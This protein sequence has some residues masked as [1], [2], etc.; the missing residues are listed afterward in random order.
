MSSQIVRCYDQWVLRRPRLTLAVVGLLTLFLGFF[1][2][3]FKLDASGDSLVLENDQALKYYIGIKQQYASDDYLVLTYTPRAPL[4]SQPVLEDLHRL[5]QALEGVDNTASVLSIL[6]VPLLAS[7]P[8]TLNELQE[9]IRT[10]RD[11]DADLALARQEFLTS[12]IYSNLLVSPEATTT[13]LLISLEVDE[14]RR[15]LRRQR[16]ALRAAALGPDFSDQQRRELAAV[17]R[18]YAD[19]SAETLARESAQIDAV[20]AIMA[21]HQNSAQLHLGGVPM[22]VADSIR[23][24][25]NDLAIFGLGVVAF[26]ITILAIAFRRPRWVLLPLMTCS[27][28][29]VLMTGFLGLVNWPVTVVS[30]NFISLL[31]II[32]LSLTIHLIVRYRELHQQRPEADQHSLVLATIR[33]KVIPCF[34]TAITT[35]VAFGSLIVSNIRPVIDFGWMMCIGIS[36]AFVLAF[37]L[38]PACLVLL[39]PGKPATTENLTARITL[40]LATLVDSR[41]RLIIAT[42]VVISLVSIA[43]ITR[44]TVE[45]RF[46]DYYKESTEIYQGMALID[47]QLGGTTPLE[48][49]I[50]APADDSEEEINDP[51]LA[52]GDEDDEDFLLDEDEWLDD[53]ESGGLTATSYWFNT[54]MLQEVAAIHDYLDALPETGKVLSLT[55]SMALL[56]QLDRQVATDNFLLAVLYKK[57]PDQLKSALFSP[58]LSADGQ[59]LRFSIRVFDSDPELQRNVLLR[60]IREELVSE[61]QLAPEQVHLTGMLVLYNNMLQSLFDSQIMTLGVVFLAILAM[62]MLLFRNLVVAFLALLPNLVA[63][64]LVLGIMGWVG[65]S[66]D[67]MTITI[68]AI[69]IGIAVDNAIH[70]VDRFSAEFAAVG[71]YQLAIARS[72]GSIGQALYY[73]CLTITLGFSILALSNFKPTIYFGLLT[74]FSMLVALL[75]NLTLLPVLIRWFKP[76]G[77]A[78]QPA[79]TPPAADDRQT[80]SVRRQ[81][82][83][84]P[85]APMPGNS[86][87]SD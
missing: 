49:I 52:I 1:A 65:I 55:S 16:D 62:F 82:A 35:I 24:I 13:A 75:A 2:G 44:L 70:Y 76:L 87:A 3:N 30:S 14:R 5:H 84:E 45:N 22:I 17:S 37:T 25:K 11:D 28:T 79:Q 86:S 26:L 7:P 77:P 12:P 80:P 41:H 27:V 31:L 48:V 61:L 64:A 69:C 15:E 78:Y 68:A 42:F 8:V 67:I 46:I 9:H 60:Q 57:L 54:E 18:Q 73:T 72:H 81:V 21:R 23:F 20:R 51:E 50:D 32:T 36:F 34:Y 33:A 38:F 6:N 39:K 71:N 19:H 10:L 56:E 47:R 59:Q 66:L 85:A 83:S 4:F 53:E 63:A 58:Y 74:G 29:V 40:W 43:G